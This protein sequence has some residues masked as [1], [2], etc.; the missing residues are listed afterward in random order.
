MYKLSRISPDDEK[1]L[2]QRNGLVAAFSEAL[3]IL[4]PLVKPVYRRLIIGTIYYYH[5]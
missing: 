3:I 1:K 2:E 4:F 5:C